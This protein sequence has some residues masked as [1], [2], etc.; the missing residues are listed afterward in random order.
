MLGWIW[1]RFV[2]ELHDFIPS[3]PS[4]GQIRGFLIFLVL[5]GVFITAMALV[6]GPWDQP[7]E[8]KPCPPGVGVGETIRD[9][10]GNVFVC[11]DF[12]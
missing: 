6:G 9:E 10:D 2:R 1:N 3:R 5:V 12:P 8:G 4:G 7:K 11:T